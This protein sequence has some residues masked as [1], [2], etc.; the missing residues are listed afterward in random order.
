[1]PVWVGLLGYVLLFVGS[2][3]HF[4][5]RSWNRSLASFSIQSLGVGLVAWQIAPL[6]LAL[7]KC[8]IGWLA[9]ALIATTIS[10]EGTVKNDDPYRLV[11]VFF[12]GILWL[13]VLSTIISLL[14]EFSLLFRNPPPGIMLVAGYLIGVGLLQIGLSE[15]PLRIGTSLLTIMQGFELGYLWLEQSLLVTGL[16]AAAELATLLSLVFLYTYSLPQL[17]GEGSE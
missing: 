1:M 5:T 16:L 12:R 9:A 3:F 4:L 17:K 10:R 7:A 8:V 14:P 2:L 13:L 11:S 15:H 6:P